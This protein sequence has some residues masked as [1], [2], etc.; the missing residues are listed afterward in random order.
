VTAST[1]T[2][3][4]ELR[5][6]AW[7]ASSAYGL[8][9]EAFAEGV[10]AGRPTARPVDAGTW[11]VPDD[12]ACLVPNFDLRTTLGKKGTRMMNRMTGLAVTTVGNLL[13][14]SA[15]PH[16][17]AQDIGLVLG[18]TMGSAQ[19]AIDLT[20]GSLTAD[21][22]FHVESGL[23]PYAVMNGTAGQCAIWHDLKGPNATLAAGRAA[24]L[25]A[26]VYARRLLL[27]RRARSVLCGA[28][29]EFSA[30]RSWLAARRT[31][32][33]GPLGEGCAMFTLTTDPR[34]PAL[35]ALAGLSTLA[36][37]DGDWETAVRRCVTRA[38]A[39]TA[40]EKVWAAIGSAAPGAPGEGE[41]AALRSL[42][43][44][45]RTAAPVGD[46]IGE[47]DSVSASFAL[48]ALLARA[49]RAP[50]ASGRLGIVTAIDPD[51]GTVAAVAVRFS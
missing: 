25:F 34:Q 40:P 24:G 3:P 32:S 15:Q 14:E 47:T 4:P 26:L 12:T 7:S 41:Q 30:A 36:C 42:F 44:P 27:T 22:P 48:A 16:A 45:G 37:A 10:L 43:G 29:E 38:L 33:A 46:L 8:G 39:G 11:P 51:G 49:A 2:A 21:Q 6:V 28:V 9:R 31:P 1:A 5:I 23:I 20:R 18:T 35:A 50:E 19:S 17:V 13:K